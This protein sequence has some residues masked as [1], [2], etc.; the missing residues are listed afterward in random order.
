M[1]LVWILIS[2]FVKNIVKVESHTWFFMTSKR[3]EKTNKLQ[4]EDLCSICVCEN[5]R[6]SRGEG[7]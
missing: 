5:G 7:K 1:N 4:R 3:E 6:I 2:W